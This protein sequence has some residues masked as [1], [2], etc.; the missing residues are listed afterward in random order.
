MPTP[1]SDKFIVP[2]GSTLRLADVDPDDTGLAD[3]KKQAKKAFA[4]DL[5]AIRDLQYALYAE[6]KQGF[7]LCLQAPDAG[8]KDGTIRSLAVGLNPQGCHVVSFKVPTE[9]ERAHDFLWRVHPHAPPRGGMSIFNRSHYEDVLVVRV[10]DLVPK[11]VWKE[12]YD[13]INAFERLLAD[14]GTRIVKIFL[15]ISKDEQLDRFA[16]RLENPGKNWKISEADY[17]ERDLWDEYTAAFEDAFSKCSTPHAPWFIIP[18]NKKWYR[19]FVIGRILREQL[20]AMNMKI[21]EPSVDI[22]DIRRR[23]FAELKDAEEA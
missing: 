7:L 10:K 2:P 4:K 12:R 18:A 20:E 17:T 19:D 8:G 16:K 6:G 5:K 13:H 21:P 23:Y 9:L 1:F 14:Q 11:P 22:D 15:C 3:G